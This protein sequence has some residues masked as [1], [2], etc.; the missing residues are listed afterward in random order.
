[1]GEWL[2]RHGVIDEPE[3]IWFFK[4]YE[5]DEV[6]FDVCQAWGIGIAVKDIYWKKKVE[7]R[8]RMWEK[9]CEYTPPTL[10]GEFPEEEFTEP[11]TKM[12][13]GITKEKLEEWEK[14]AEEKEGDI[15]TGVA[16]SFGVAEGPAVVIPRFSE[17]H[18]VKNGDIMVTSTMAPAWGP[19][20]AGSKAMVLDSGGNM[21]RAAIV[22]RE[23]GV[24]AVTGTRF[25]T[26]RIKTGDTIR[27]DGNKGIVEIIKRAEG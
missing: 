22:A 14:A 15:L 1:M 4:R 23:E 27:V 17:S 9:F 8:K 16:A 2:V 18:K 10:L 21:C 13:W 5:F 11:V 12:L 24:P 6:V 7:K 26:Q 19:V 3:D 25:A 20:L